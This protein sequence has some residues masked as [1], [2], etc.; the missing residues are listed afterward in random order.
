MYENSHIHEKTNS[1]LCQLVK[2]KFPP[3]NAHAKYKTLTVLLSH[4]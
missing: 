1:N 2:N 3:N 4:V